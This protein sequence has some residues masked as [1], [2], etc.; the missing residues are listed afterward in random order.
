[1]QFSISPVLGKSLEDFFNIWRHFV[2]YA[3]CFRKKDLFEVKENDHSVHFADREICA[4]LN[5][6]VVT[7]MEKELEHNV[8]RVFALSNTQ[9]EY[10]WGYQ[11]YKAHFVL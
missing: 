5:E 1:M 10:S 6:Y 7:E 11:L 2:F 8:W 4:K 9:S 3:L